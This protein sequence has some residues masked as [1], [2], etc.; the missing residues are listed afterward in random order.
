M[1]AQKKPHKYQIL[2]NFLSKCIIGPLEV[3]HILKREEKR[4]TVIPYSHWKCP[5]I[6]CMSLFPAKNDGP[7]QAKF[8]KQIYL[9]LRA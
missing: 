6:F 5:L 4:I 2:I 3:L 1:V 7:I 9:Y 8:S